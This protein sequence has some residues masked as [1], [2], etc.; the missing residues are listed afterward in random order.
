MRESS[1]SLQKLDQSNL[2]IFVS[3]EVCLCAEAF[4]ACVAEV[5]SFTEN[6][7]KDHM[8]TGNSWRERFF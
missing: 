4:A 5:T 2:P 6:Q 3:S 8:K 7:P 1:S